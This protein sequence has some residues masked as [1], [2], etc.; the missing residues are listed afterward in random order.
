M[1]YHPRADKDLGRD[2]PICERP[3]CKTATTTNPRTEASSHP[4]NST[5]LLPNAA[6]QSAVAAG[7][8]SN[9]M[10]SKSAGD[11]KNQVQ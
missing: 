11:K 10:T 5:Q 9:S 7:V 3:Q 8:F 6:T 1:S 4:I 2:P